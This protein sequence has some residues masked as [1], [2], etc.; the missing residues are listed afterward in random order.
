[1]ALR[2]VGSSNPTVAS[3]YGVMTKAYNGDTRDAEHGHGKRIWAG[4]RG[5]ADGGVA[6]EMGN[7]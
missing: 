1:M 5:M 4:D 2:Q 6:G 7:V 3:V